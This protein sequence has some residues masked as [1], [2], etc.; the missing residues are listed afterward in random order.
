MFDLTAMDATYDATSLKES[1]A[2]GIIADMPSKDVYANG[3]LIDKDAYYQTIAS[4]VTATGWSNECSVKYGVAVAQTQIRSIPSPHFI[5]YSATDSDDEVTSSALRVNEPFVIK[6]VATVGGQTFYYGYSNNVPGWVASSDIAICDTK[7]QWLDA[8]QTSLT[9]NDFIVVTGDYFTLSESVYSRASSGL[10]LTM[11]TTLKLVPDSSI[12]RNIAMRGTWN[13]YVVYIPTRKADGGYEK[14]MA[15]IAQNKPV[16]EGYLPLTS[17]NMLSLAFSYLG[18]TYGWG[19][20]LDSV[21]CSLYVRNIYKCFGL[22]MPRNTN[23]QQSVAGTKADISAYDA[24][25]KAALISKC[26]PGTPL[27][28]SGHTMIYI[29][30]V[31]GVNYCISALGSVADSAGYVDVVTENSVTI[32]SLLVRRRNGSTW[33]ENIT[34]AVIPWVI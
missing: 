16:N 4:A 23:W 7:A 20:M 3:S 15:L 27:Y 34:S 5:G 28:M 32:T 2:Q 6:Q 19:G 33:L 25:T 11:G 12:P 30:T 24:A 22:E 8:W 26:A 10:K 17:N 29:G 21:D 18:D 13:N 14:Q 31:D 9:G 1:L